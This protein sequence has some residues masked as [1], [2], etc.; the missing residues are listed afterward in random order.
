MNVSIFTPISCL[1]IL[2]FCLNNS[3]KI[4]SATAAAATIIM[5]LEST[6]TYCTVLL[7]FRSF[8]RTVLKISTSSFLFCSVKES[9]FLLSGRN[10]MGYASAF[11]H[12][13][14]IFNSF[15]RKN[16]HRK[17]KEKENQFEDNTLE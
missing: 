2:Y 11:F 8:I 3:K 10:T 17:Y 4:T 12:F 14:F 1:S 16:A 7:F 9:R 5:K 13:C 6:I 15:T